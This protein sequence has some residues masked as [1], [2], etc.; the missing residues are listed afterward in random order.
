MNSNI[1]KIGPGKIR[2]IEST[3]KEAEIS[4]KILYVSDPYVDS[5]YGTNLRC[6]TIIKQKSFFQQLDKIFFCKYF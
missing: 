6:N 5:L 2:E 4:G 1:L 3:L